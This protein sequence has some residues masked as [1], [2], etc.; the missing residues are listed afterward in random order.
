MSRAAATVLVFLLCLLMAVNCGLGAAEKESFQRIAARYAAQIR[1]LLKAYCVPC[2]H[3]QTPE[4]DLDLDALKTLNDARRNPRVWQKVL[5]MIDNAEMPPKA[6][7]QL[8]AAELTTLTNWVRTYLNAEALA[9]AGDPGR[10]IM[11]RLSNA[12]YDNTIRDLTGVDFRATREFP[13]DSAAGEGFTNAGESMVMSPALFEKYVAA[14]QEI[15]AHV[16]FLPDGFRFS[17]ASARRDQTDEVIDQILAIYANKTELVELRMTGGNRDGRIRWGHLPLT[18]YIKVLIA[19]REKLT[20]QDYFRVLAKA[21]GL[22]PIY[23]GHLS[24]LLAAQHPSPLLAQ[25]QEMLRTASAD[26][27]DTVD[28]ETAAIVDWIKHWQNQLIALEDIGQLFTPGQQPLT[29]ITASQE[30][31]LA[32]TPPVTARRSELSLIAHAGDGNAEGRAIWKD[33]RLEHADYGTVP[34]RDLL[35]WF[36]RVSEFRRVTLARTEEYLAA[37]AVAATAQQQS[38]AALA[39]ARDLEPDLLTAWTDYLDIPVGSDHPTQVLGLIRDKKTAVAGLDW[40]KGWGATPPNIIANSSETET[41]KVPGD[42]PP[43]TVGIHPTP[44]QYVGVGWK[45]PITGSVDIEALVIDR[46]AGGNGVEWWLVAQ[47]GERETRLA[48]GVAADGQA[49]TIPAVKAHVVRTGDVLSLR[50]GPRDAN[51]ASDQTQIDLV[52]TEQKGKSRTWNLAKD[53][54]ADIH[55]G[56]PHADSLGNP[57]VWYFYTGETTSDA[58][59]Q[60]TLPAGCLL[61]RWRTAIDA[62][63][64]DEAAN[65]AK[66]VAALLASERVENVSD[67]DRRLY[68]QTRAIDSPLFKQFDREAFKKLG[69]A[70]RRG[71]DSL[72]GLGVDPAAFVYNDLV[73]NIPHSLAITIPAEFATGWTFAVSG[74]LS[75]NATGF[76]QLE[77]ANGRRTPVKGFKAGLPFLV[78]PGH[79]GHDQ[80]QAAFDDFRALFPRA[81]CCRTIVPIDKVITLVMYHRED[82]HFRRLLLTEQERE[83]LDRLWR[84]VRYISQDALKIHEFYP[85]FLEFSTQGNDTHVF[86]PL[87][88]PIRKRAETFKKHLEETAPAQIHALVNFAARAFRRPLD[89]HEVQSLRSMYTN[90]RAQKEGHEAALRGVLTRVLV[91]PGFLYRIEQPGPGTESVPVTDYELATRLSYFLWSTTPDRELF[92]SATSRTLHQPAALVTQTRRMLKDGRVR[93]LATEFACQWL[94]IRTF[95]SHD[96]KNEKQYPTFAAV[97][98]DMFEESVHFFEDLFQRDG[99]VLEI[100][101]ADHTFMNKTLAEHYGFNDV[102]GASWQRV[103]GMKQRSRGGVLGMGAILAK[104]SGATR[105]SPVLRG[106][107]VVETLLGEKLPDPPATVPELPDALSRTGLTVRQMTERHVADPSCAKCHARIDPFGFALESFDAIGRYRDTDLIGK[108]V[109]TKVRLR[110]GVQFEGIE[111]LRNYLLTHRRDDFLEQFCRKLLGFA[112]GRTVQLSDQPLVDEMVTQL[113]KN[114]HR[115]STAVETIV[116]SQ[117]FRFHRG[118]ESTHEEAR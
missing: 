60:V 98:H 54:S 94:G 9:N 101:N 55:A 111:G 81:M 17:K 90:L 28:R 77:A 114:D 93:A 66:A 78:R 97:R 83:R 84:E 103:D 34:L 48:S 39:K 116:G 107:W 62:G 4:G 68:R 3:S 92:S 22:N 26:D 108:P 44:T 104:Q 74:E 117:Q 40:I 52:I 45:S 89:Q 112:V 99:S 14:A 38:V 57:Q 72:R 42:V 16:V 27:T 15:A 6:S 51:H 115:I 118:L 7:K 5:F 67:A 29:P 69:A 50:V 23:L 24:R 11:R 87:K 71:A 65:L 46:H 102:T 105:T 64:I 2:H 41:A 37:V 33:A 43:R 47:R 49:V 79:P 61:A 53:V 95:S 1:P 110:D 10:V 36:N 82:K 20:N 19:H 35:P 63:E 59:S 88:E 31:R 106:N 109:D 13:A 96:E 91:S 80:L 100:L 86:L 25:L 56:N 76:V 30:F 73:T 75:G 70:G 85:L 8:A 32:L 58:P 18:P 113:R 21:N 12:E